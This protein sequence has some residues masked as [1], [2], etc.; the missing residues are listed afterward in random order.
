MLLDE[1]ISEYL[2][3][4]FDNVMSDLLADEVLYPVVI[5]FYLLL[6]YLF[7]I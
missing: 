5:K 6:L 3:K 2:E 1:V 4:A 7:R